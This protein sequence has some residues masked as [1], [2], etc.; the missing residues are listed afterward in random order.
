MKKYIISI[1]MVLLFSVPAQA[2]LHTETIEYKQGDAVLEEY[3][4]Y[5]D[6]IEGNVP[7]FWLYMNGK[8]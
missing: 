8:D 4:A 5:D 7:A 6:A 3:W 2:A 1:L